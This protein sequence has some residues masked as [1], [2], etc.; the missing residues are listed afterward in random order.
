[1]IPMVSVLL[2]TIF[3]LAACAQI[4]D[5]FSGPKT[6]FNGDSA[7]SYAKQQLAFGP[8]TPGTAAHD[9]AGDWIVAQMKRRTDSVTVQSWVQTTANGTKLPLKNIL[10]RF[11]PAATSRVLYLTHWDTRPTADEDPNFGNKA[12]PILGANDG[13]SGVGLLIALADVFKQTPPNFGVDLLFVDG[14]DW[15]SFNA[16]STGRYPDALFGSQYFADHPPSPDY[17]PLFGVLFDMIGDKDLQLYQEGNSLQNAPEVVS[18][19]WRTAADLGYGA[20]FRDQPMTAVIDDHV[21]LE[22]KGMH[23][24]DVIDLQYGVL[25]P[26]AGPNDLPN[27]NY[28]HT[29]EDPIDKISAKSLQIVGDVAV[30]LVK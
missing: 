9:S 25:P 14:E 1:M 29:L 20:Y 13:A 12:R 22:Q 30:T 10:A 28:H 23:V 24:I 2:C 27:P 4:K 17:K 5:R 3:A 16:D 11:N 7:L 21:P 26:N 18:R 6:D 15:G 8:R 19:V